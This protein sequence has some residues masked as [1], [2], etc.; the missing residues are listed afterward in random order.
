[1][2]PSPDALDGSVD[3]PPAFTYVLVPADDASPVQELTSACLGYAGDALPSL[4]AARFATAAAPSRGSSSAASDASTARVLAAAAT[5]KAETFALVHPADTNGNRGVYLYVDEVGKLRG[6]P[7]NARAADLAAR[8]GLSPPPDADAP[9]LA[10][11]GD[12]L[13]GAVRT[14][15]D[16]RNASFE[17]RELEPDAAWL[18]RAP[19]E[20]AAY[21]VVMRDF[22]AAVASKRVTDAQAAEIRAD[23]EGRA[24]ARA[25]DDHRNPHRDA[26]D[27]YASA[28]VAESIANE[29]ARTRTK[30]AT[31]AAPEKGGGG[32][33]RRPAEVSSYL[34]ALVDARDA[35]VFASASGSVGGFGLVARRDVRR[36]EVLWCERPVASVQGVEN[37]R[38]TLACASCHRTVGTLDAYLA[39]ASGA[40]SNARDAADALRAAG[41]DALEPA[42]IDGGD[43][44]TTRA[45]AFGGLLRGTSGDFG[46]ASRAAAAVREVTTEVDGPAP[47]RCHRR[48]TRGCDATYCSKACRRAHVANGHD[49]SCCPPRRVVRRA[50]EDRETEEEDESFMTGESTGGRRSS[51][52][53]SASA[54]RLEREAHDTVHLV[55]DAVGRVAAA[56]ARGAAFEDAAAP[57]RAFVSRPWWDDDEEEEEEGGAGASA[58]GGGGEGGDDRRAL[59]RRIAARAMAKL[60]RAATAAAEGAAEEEASLRTARDENEDLEDPED[61]EAAELVAEGAR[62][63]AAIPGVLAELGLDGFGALLGA[64]DLNQWSVRV[65]GPMRNAAREI[66]RLDETAGADVADEI[67]RRI[68][69]TAI[70]AQDLRDAE[71]LRA[72]RPR[73][74]GGGGGDGENAASDD[75]DSSD[76]DDSVE[77]EARVDE[78]SDAEDLYDVSRRLF[79]MLVG[80]A[81][82]PLLC[83]VNHACEPNVATRFSSWKGPATVRVEAIRDV[84]E[85]EEL[86][87]SYVDETA[88]YDERRDALRAYGFACACAKC[89]REGGEMRVGSAGA[90]DVD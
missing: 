17:A 30:A 35:P 56:V 22:V 80:Q 71:D 59:L 77:V 14:D 88:P 81:L 53:A 32:D 68:L 52:S 21:A 3:R 49:L 85:G 29:E 86:F 7:A 36:G 9:P 2:V 40:I 84:R 42:I 65:D 48:R 50:I 27:A 60:R 4:A 54:F 90:E 61:L 23:A 72:G 78:T 87:V 67:V 6:A 34:S 83:V 31:K 28:L 76:D 63:C 58:G 47:V 38:E 73:W 82:F 57:F 43:E 8:C 5:G 10:F 25:S 1:M 55:A 46:A 20:N 45:R 13:V 74:G 24:R 51:A 16:V 69:P 44:K 39:L 19:A 33:R 12:V 64:C 26:D 79:P 62:T 41:G 66:L 89:A 75:A 11:H 37:A 15:P 18:L 70:A